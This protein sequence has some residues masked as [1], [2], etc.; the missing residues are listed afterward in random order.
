MNASCLPALCP[1]GPLSNATKA[2][3]TTLSSGGRD[4]DFHFVNQ[5]ALTALSQLLQQNLSIK[6]THRCQKSGPS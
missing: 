3:L 5:M 1:P 2:F 4:P 6:S